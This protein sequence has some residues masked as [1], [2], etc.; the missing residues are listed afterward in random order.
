MSDFNGKIFP[1]VYD[2]TIEIK[3][4]RND[5]GSLVR[6]FNSQQNI[7][8]KG[9]ATVSNGEFSFQ[10]VVPKD[11]N[12]ALGE[13]K[14]SYYATDQ[15]SRD[16][17][18]AFSNFQVGGAD[19][20]AIQDD[21]GPL[22]EVF[23]DDESFVFGGTTDENPILLVKLSDD[24]GINVAGSSVGHDLTGVL[25]EDTQNSYLLNDFYESEL[26]DFTKGTVRFPLFDLEE[27]RH[28]VRVKAWDVA[29]NSSEGFTEFVVSK[30]SALALQHVLNYPNPFTTNTNF[31][32][33]HNLEGQLVDVQIRIF[34]ISGVL[35]KTITEE[36]V[37]SEGKRVT[38]I[39]WDGLNDFGG[40]LARGIYLYKV[41][42]APSNSN[43]EI[44]SAES[45]FEK[46]VILK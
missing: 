7:I 1:I 16:A 11:I 24:S 30:T 42:V 20:N 10:F 15:I 18:G 34:T 36:N 14:I 17:T 29:N 3:T 40:Q 21:Q 46:L 8:F 35:V 39:Q 5:P 32:F 38:G 26:D 19:Q 2:K 27:G 13:G 44:E 9:A 45:E 41:K 6:G 28:E 43:L 22:V 25:D 33:E 31:L 37:L 23:M 4:L 12:Y